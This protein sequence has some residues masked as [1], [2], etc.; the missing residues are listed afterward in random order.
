MGLS[1]SCSPL[2]GVLLSLGLSGA[3]C[4]PKGWAIMA[5]AARVS[6]DRGHPAPSG[7]QRLEGQAGGHKGSTPGPGGGCWSVT[8]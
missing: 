3:L 2:A 6:S 7:G 5:L 8:G 1:S 4:P